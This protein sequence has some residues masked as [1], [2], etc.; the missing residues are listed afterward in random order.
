VNNEINVVIADD[1][2]NESP[3]FTLHSVPN[4]SNPQ[5]QNESQLGHNYPS[6][7]NPRQPFNRSDDGKQ[8]RY[9]V[10]ADSEPTRDV[11]LSYSTEQLQDNT[12]PQY[13]NT[14]SLGLMSP[15][16]PHGCPN[17]AVLR[18]SQ[19]TVFHHASSYRGPQAP[20]T[21]IPQ[22]F[23]WNRIPIQG[24]AARDE[25]DEWSQVFRIYGTAI[26]ILWKCG[27]SQSD[28]ISQSFNSWIDSQSPKIHSLLSQR[29]LHVR[30]EVYHVAQTTVGYPNKRKDLKEAIRMAVVA[31]NWPGDS[32]FSELRVHLEEIRKKA[33]EMLD[34]FP[35]EWALRKENP[36]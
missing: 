8:Y 35:D 14:Q 26:G 25:S 23:G 19:R 32:D 4:T 31:R 16:Y 11:Y 10:A 5:G 2:D 15:G 1:I 22:Q 9:V 7:D 20:I 17:P 21:Q 36:G 18:E 12:N 27:N 3:P 13:E 24:Q 30:P 29:N 34:R 6:L 28:E 33:L